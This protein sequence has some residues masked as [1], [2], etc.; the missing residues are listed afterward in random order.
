MWLSIYITEHTQAFID[1]T[2]YITNFPPIYA[3]IKVSIYLYIYLYA[4]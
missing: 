3:S 1:L 4:N 2:K